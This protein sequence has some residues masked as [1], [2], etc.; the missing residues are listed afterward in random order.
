MR[1]YL[2]DERPT[3]KGWVRTYSARATIRLLQTGEV[4]ELSLDHD[5]GGGTW[6]APEFEPFGNGYE[7]LVWLEEQV[8][9]HGFKPPKLY[10]HTANSAARVR[11][12][13]AVEAIEAFVEGNGTG[14][15]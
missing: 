13:Q 7:V 12:E 4:T 1:V 14:T 6:D 15:V 5:L 2:D 8:M 11:M 3:P 10:V 9:V